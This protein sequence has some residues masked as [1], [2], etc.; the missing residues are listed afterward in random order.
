MTEM[1][2]AQADPSLGTQY[3]T[4]LILWIAMLL[5]TVMYLVVTLVLPRRAAPENHLL[6]IV[7]SAVAAFMVVVSF[8]VRSKFLSRSVETQ[9]TQLVKSGFVVG[10]ALCEAAAILGLLD[11]LIAHDRYYIVLI[12]FSFLGLL[13][14][15]PRGSHLVAASGG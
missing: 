2:N 13:L 1:T 4:M 12:A 5:T 14:Q 11:F 3:Q 15:F 7:F 9:D 6:T 8:A 10:A